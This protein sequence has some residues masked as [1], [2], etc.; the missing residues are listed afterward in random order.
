MGKPFQKDNFCYDAEIETYIC[1][2]REILYRRRTYEYKNKQRITYWTNECK[3]CVMKEI[4]C[5]KKNYRTIQYYGNPS[6]IRMQRKM[7][8]D[9][10]KKSTKNDQKQQNYHLHT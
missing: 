7:E 1:P 5:K 4:C 8:T 2:L 6:K 9:G 10:H 3:N